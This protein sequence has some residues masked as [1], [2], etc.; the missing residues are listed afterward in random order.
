MDVRVEGLLAPSGR[1]QGKIILYNILLVN[2]YKKERLEK[3]VLCR[4]LRTKLRESLSEP[5]KHK[6]PLQHI[7]SR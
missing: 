5:D 6:K 7:P 1:G 3:A 4:E 2:V